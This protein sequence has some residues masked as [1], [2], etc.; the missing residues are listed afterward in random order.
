[1]FK[2]HTRGSLTA[3]FFCGSDIFGIA[4]RGE[5]CHFEEDAAENT[6][7]NQMKQMNSESDFAELREIPCVFDFAV[8]FPCVSLQHIGKLKPERR[9]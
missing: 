3:F 1:M 8:A 5:V 2:F 7:Q 6:Q 9:F 4:N